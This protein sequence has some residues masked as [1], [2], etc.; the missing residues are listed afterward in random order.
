MEALHRRTKERKDSLRNAVKA[1]IQGDKKQG[2][3]VN[4]IMAELAK[5]EEVTGT[6][7]R[8]IV[9]LLVNEMEGKESLE[10]KGPFI[11]W[12][13]GRDLCGKPDVPRD[14]PK[15]VAE[16]TPPHCLCC[17]NTMRIVSADSS[18]MGQLGVYA[19][20]CDYCPRPR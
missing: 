14:T 7:N 13:H 15:E 11:R 4:E 1:I 3:S 16:K 5:D 10:R 12:N 19:V 9:E 17:G 6:F 20:V 2:S 18:V 8:A